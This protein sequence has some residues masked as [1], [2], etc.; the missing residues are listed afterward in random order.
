MT[1]NDIKTMQLYQ[2]P[3]RILA[4]LRAQGL[5]VGAPL[6]VEALSRFDQL[7]YHGTDALDVA[8]SE[9]GIHGGESVLEVGSGWGG[10]ARYIANKTGTR[11]TAVELQSDYD[12]IARDLTARVTLKG[13]VEHVNADFLDLDLPEKEF[14]HAAS[15]LALFHIPHREAYLGKLHHTLKPGGFLFVEDLYLIQQ[16]D[17]DEAD[18][19]QQHLRPGS[20]ID[21]EAY[22]AALKHAGFDVVHLADM[23]ADWTDFTVTRLQAFRDA[24]SDYEAVHGREGYATI[25]IF[26]TKMAGYFARG[27]VGGVR[28][29]AVRRG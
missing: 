23:T 4:D 15:W 17:P 24:R 26:Y 28:F 25:E 14:D 21:R 5:G 7:H 2:R 19:F 9:C 13:C 29:A 3:T 10:C 1:N 11:V 27:L 16:P 12:Q 20:L 22:F 6:T 18:D 8:I